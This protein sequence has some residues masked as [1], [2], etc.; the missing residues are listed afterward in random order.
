MLGHINPGVSLLM[1]FRRQISFPKMV[2]YWIAQFAG[3]LLGA[4][5]TWGCTSGLSGEDKSLLEVNAGVVFYSRPPFEL[6]STTLNDDITTGNGF[7][8]EFMGS[9]FFYLVI[10]QTALDKRGI[11]GS[12]FPAFPIG[13]I[14]IVVHICLIRTYPSNRLSLFGCLFCCRRVRLI[15]ISSYVY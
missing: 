6:G 1:Y 14:L 8:I 15:S 12:F 4:A 9:F 7:L 2:V 5:L 10:A 3:S 11:A 13:F